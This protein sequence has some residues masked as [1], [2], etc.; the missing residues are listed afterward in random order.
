MVESFVCLAWRGVP[1]R[2]DEVSGDV[3]VMMAIGR[4]VTQLRC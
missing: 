4:A 2:I 3:L 1:T